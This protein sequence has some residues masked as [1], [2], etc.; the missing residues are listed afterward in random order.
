MGRRLPL[1]VQIGASEPVSKQQVLTSSFAPGC[2]RPHPE[3][4]FKWAP[5][6]FFLFSDLTVWT[7]KLQG[8]QP[9][10]RKAALICFQVC[11]RLEREA[12]STLRFPVWPLRPGGWNY[13]DVIWRKGTGTWAFISLRRIFIPFRFIGWSLSLLINQVCPSSHNLSTSHREHDVMEGTLQAGW[14]S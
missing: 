12:A 6:F 9:R 3:L 13:P 5:E 14:E 10:N 8:E 2:W 11:R 1:W 7:S 4:V